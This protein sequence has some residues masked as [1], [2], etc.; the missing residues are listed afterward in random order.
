M[1]PETVHLSIIFIIRTMSVS[2]WEDWWLTKISKA[3]V[4]SCKLTINRLVVMLNWIV[5]LFCFLLNIIF[6]KRLNRNK[7]SS[8]K[9]KHK[10]SFLTLWTAWSAVRVKF[11]GRHPSLPACDTHVFIWHLWRSLLQVLSAV[12]LPQLLWLQ[13]FFSSLGT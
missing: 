10:K 3:A 8:G 2:V 13:M 12:L 5:F 11:Y 7:H 1:E 4:P 9:I 6:A